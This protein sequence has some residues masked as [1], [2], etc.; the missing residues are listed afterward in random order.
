MLSRD[1]Q[2]HRPAAERNRQPILN[3]LQRCLPARGKAL[4][5][6]SGTG[7]HAVHFAAGLPG[8]T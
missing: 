5:I 7:Q 8:W 3:L 4:E 2:L 6:V 1:A